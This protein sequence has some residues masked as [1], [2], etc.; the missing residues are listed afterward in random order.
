MTGRRQAIVE[1]A[2]E[3]KTIMSL[4]GRAVKKLERRLKNLD[5]DISRASDFELYRRLG[6]LLQINHGRIQKGMS[7]I[8]VADVYAD[9]SAEIEI[10]LDPARSPSENIDDYFK[11]YRKGREGLEL[12]RR[13]QEI[14]RRELEQLQIM[15]HD[16]DTG[17]ETALERYRAEIAALRPHSARKGETQVRQ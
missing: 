4:L 6:E 8:L 2:D 5:G 3:Q 14:S 13:R 11:Q 1:E 9:P 16:F 7:G 15:T 12:L 10:S 17:F